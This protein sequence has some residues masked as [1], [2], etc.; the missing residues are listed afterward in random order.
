MMKAKDAIRE[1][2]RTKTSLELELELSK[3]NPE[4]EG[5]LDERFVFRRERAKHFQ[6]GR[7]FP[8]LATPRLV[9]SWTLSE[10]GRQNAEH[11]QQA[12]P[13]AGSSGSGR[14]KIRSPSARLV[15]PTVSLSRKHQ[16]KRPESLNVPWLVSGTAGAS[17]LISD[18]KPALFED[19]YDDPHAL[20]LAEAKEARLRL[21]EEGVDASGFLPVCASDAREIC[22]RSRLNGQ[23]GIPDWLMYYAVKEDNAAAK[24]LVD[25]LGAMELA[26]NRI[27]EEGRKQNQSLQ[28]RYMQKRKNFQ[29]QRAA[30]AMSSFDQFRLE[31]AEELQRELRRKAANKLEVKKEPNLM[32]D[33]QEF[34]AFRIN[35]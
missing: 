9:P 31:K 33:F 3:V 34:G 16:A 15:Q 1:A 26:T 32:G 13:A 14:R 30:D 19:S 12:Q 7:H 20:A 28:E 6:V 5:L 27:R 17:D 10:A 2:A 25:K 23:N 21:L 11:P 35:K 24:R 8:A 4:L 18:R 22:D 29:S